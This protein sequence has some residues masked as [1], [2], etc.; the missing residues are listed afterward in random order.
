MTITT[1]P[2]YV[3]TFAHW[4]ALPESEFLFEIEQGR[5]VPLRPR[6]LHQRAVIKVCRELSGRIQDELEVVYRPALVVSASDPPTVRMPDVVIVAAELIDANP[7]YLSVADV[8]GVVEVVE[9]GSR[10]VDLMTKRTEYAAAGI[11]CYS[12]IDLKAFDLRSPPLLVHQWEDDTA[13]VGGVR[14]V[15]RAAFDFD[16]GALLRRESGRPP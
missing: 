7:E 11:P 15:W 2:E 16:L 4:L 1:H 14:M 9:P 8:L 6:P 13:Q 12:T 5:A 3:P 10:D